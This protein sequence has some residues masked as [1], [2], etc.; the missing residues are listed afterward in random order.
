M[1]NMW[2]KGLA[3]QSFSDVLRS[4]GAKKVRRAGLVNLD[5]RLREGTASLPQVFT[6]RQGGFQKSVRTLRKGILILFIKCFSR[7]HAGE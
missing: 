4:N 7:G 3:L 1:L 5:S 2:S 6:S